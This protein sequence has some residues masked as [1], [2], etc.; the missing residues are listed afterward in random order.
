MSAPRMYSIC[1][2][3]T[4][5]TTTTTTTITTTTS[6]SFLSTFSCPTS[7][8]HRFSGPSGGHRTP[9]ART[10]AH[11]P[12]YAGCLQPG[13]SPERTSPLS[14]HWLHP[15]LTFIQNYLPNASTPR[16]HR[17]GALSARP[18]TV[19][20]ASNNAIPPRAASQVGLRREYTFQGYR[21]VSSGPSSGTDTARTSPSRPQSTVYRAKLASHPPAFGP[22]PVRTTNS[23]HV[24]GKGRSMSPS[25]PS[26]DRPA[27][28]GWA[29]GIVRT[30]RERVRVGSFANVPYEVRFSSPFHFSLL[31]HQSSTIAGHPTSYPRPHQTHP[32]SPSRHRRLLTPCTPYAYVQ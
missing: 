26:L 14:N 32:R 15:S 7:Y 10:H 17:L 9:A 5:T 19:T 23:G 1:F 24:F 11:S 30:E 22:N 12:L 13:Y 16:R 8:P 21:A 31:T 6:I 4:T 20:F 18:T 28:T 27:G 25:K 2:Y 29:T 3:S